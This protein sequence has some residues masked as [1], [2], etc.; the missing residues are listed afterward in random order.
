MK[1]I[2]LKK[3]NDIKNK[4]RKNRAAILESILPDLTRRSFIGL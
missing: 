2:K 3:I 4:T 1:S